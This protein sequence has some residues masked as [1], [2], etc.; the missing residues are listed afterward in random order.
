MTCCLSSQERAV[1]EELIAYT[2]FPPAPAKPWQKSLLTEGST[3]QVLVCKAAEN[4]H[5]KGG[6]GEDYTCLVS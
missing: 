5:G 4:G 1:A 3:R 6:M 2:G